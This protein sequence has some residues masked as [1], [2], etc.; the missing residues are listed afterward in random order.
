VVQQEQLL[1][2]QERVV[3]PLSKSA[4]PITDA[5]QVVA[6]VVAFQ[7]ERVSVTRPVAAVAAARVIIM[8]I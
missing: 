2:V 1:P 8:Y 3:I 7:M 5:Y 6:V 4:V